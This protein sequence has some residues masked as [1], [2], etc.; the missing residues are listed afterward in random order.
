MCLEHLLIKRKKTV[1]TKQRKEAD[2]TPHKKITVAD[3]TDDIALLPNAPAQ[4]ETRLHYLERANAG[5][6]LHVNAH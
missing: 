4:A 1:S 2:V 5:I 3:Y 6:G